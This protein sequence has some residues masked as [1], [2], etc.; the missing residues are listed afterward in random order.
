M[1]PGVVPARVAPACQVRPLLFQLHPESQTVASAFLGTI[2]RQ[3]FSA[4]LSLEIDTLHHSAIPRDGAATT[5]YAR[6]RARATT[7]P[8][9]SSSAGPARR[10]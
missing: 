8:L 2:V 4:N 10:F 1:V 7:R 3:C 9:A 6:V 5:G